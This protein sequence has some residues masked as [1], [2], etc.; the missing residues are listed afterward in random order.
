MQLWDFNA[1]EYTTDDFQPDWPVSLLVKFFSL[2]PLT[3]RDKT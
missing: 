1:F 2:A 3:V